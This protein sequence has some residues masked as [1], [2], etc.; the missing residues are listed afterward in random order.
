MKE[1]AV[2]RPPTSLLLFRDSFCLVQCLDM[3]DLASWLQ[4][5]LSQNQRTGQR[6][7]FRVRRM[8]QLEAEELRAAFAW[9]AIYCHYMSIL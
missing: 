8:S 4:A 2:K 9:G 5:E 7:G 6:L 1:K 3:N